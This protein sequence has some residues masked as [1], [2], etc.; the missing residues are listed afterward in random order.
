M[1]AQFALGIFRQV[2]DNCMFN[3]KPIAPATAAIGLPTVL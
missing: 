3:N 1:P 2:Q